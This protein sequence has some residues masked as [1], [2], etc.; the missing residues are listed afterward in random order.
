LRRW[1]N[2]KIKV[3]LL[4]FALLAQTFGEMLLEIEDPDGFPALNE[5]IAIKV[6]NFWRDPAIQVKSS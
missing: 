4:F 6:Q 5:E 3:N 1:L 2:S